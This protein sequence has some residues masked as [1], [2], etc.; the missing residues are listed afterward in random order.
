[1]QL[2]LKLINDKRYNKI[3]E[4]SQDVKNGVNRREKAWALAKRLFID[5]LFEKYS[6]ILPRQVNKCP[7]LEDN[8]SHNFF[9]K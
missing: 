5:S 7:Q 4:E 9:Y 8:S 2:S 3:E 1:M 6:H